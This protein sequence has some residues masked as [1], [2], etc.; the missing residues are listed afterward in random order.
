M[1]RISPPLTSNETASSLVPCGSSGGSVKSF[2][3]SRGGAAAAGLHLA[4]LA[5]DHHARE[6]CS[7][8]AARVAGGDLLAQPQDGRGVAQPLHLLELMTDV[9]DG[10]A[11]PL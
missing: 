5:A 1:P 6:R 7:G 9:E 3:T 8:L 4:D 11:L 2:T 10:T